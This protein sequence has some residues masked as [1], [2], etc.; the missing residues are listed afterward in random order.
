VGNCRIDFRYAGRGDTPDLFDLAIMRKVIGGFLWAAIG[1]VA[2]TYIGG[3]L[4]YWFEGKGMYSWTWFPNFL[5]GILN[6]LRRLSINYAHHSAGGRSDE[7]TPRQE[8]ELRWRELGV[9]YQ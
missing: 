4:A 9:N 6:D 1:F 3:F 2:L 5:I 7:L 8:R